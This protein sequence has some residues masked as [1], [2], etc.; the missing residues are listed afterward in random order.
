MKLWESLKTFMGS[1]RST[2]TSTP[3]NSINELFLSMMDGFKRISFLLQQGTGT[4]HHT[5]GKSNTT[6]DEQKKLDIIA[7]EIMIHWLMKSGVCGAIISEENEEPIVMDLLPNGKRG[8]YLVAIDPLDGSSNIECNVGVGTIFAIWE[9][10]EEKCTKSVLTTEDLL[11]SGNEIIWA[12]YCIYGTSTQL[13]LTKTKLNCVIRYILNPRNMNFYPDNKGISLPPLSAQKR[14]YSINEGNHASWD[15]RTAEGIARIK[16]HSDPSPYSLRY[17]GSMVSD[18]HRTILYGGIFLY[19]ADKKTGKGKLRLLY[20]AFPMAAIMEA[21]GGIAISDQ[22]RTSILNIVPTEIH[23]KCSVI[24]G[25]KR[26]VDLF[27]GC[28]SEVPSMEPSSSDSKQ[29][30]PTELIL[31]D[32]LRLPLEVDNDDSLLPSG[33]LRS[34]NKVDSH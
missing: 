32:N 25:G 13:V 28:T 10:S 23:Q 29:G 16:A 26:D 17:V 4:H 18:I 9:L 8:K 30:E 15:D 1:G 27:Y 24:M 7:N 33:D 20:E 31:P 3:D 11:M 22:Y 5:M 2:P 21:A 6:G 34:P 14:I 12:G 19:P